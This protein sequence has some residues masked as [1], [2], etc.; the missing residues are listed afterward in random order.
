MYAGYIVEEAPVKELY[1]A[2]GHPYTKGLLG[3]LPRLDANERERLASIEGIP[4]VLY[5]KASTCP[6]APRCPYRIDHCFNENPKLME[7]SPNHK[8]ACWVDIENRK[9]R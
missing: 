1:R 3:S 6:F 5:R 9:E 2:P 7:I 4:P 8:V